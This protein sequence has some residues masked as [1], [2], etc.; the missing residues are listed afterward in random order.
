VHSVVGEH[1]PA[2]LRR[3]LIN[4]MRR[5]DALLLIL[6]ERT[7]SSPGLLSWEIEIAVTRCKL[8]II[9]T[10]TRCSDVDSLKTC[11]SSWWPDALR[12][13]TTDGQVRAV[14]VPFHPRALAQAFCSVVA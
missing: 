6:S 13:T 3:E 4:R 11:K 8:P 7:P 12:R 10:Y 1:K 14:H 5:S 2:D 9:C